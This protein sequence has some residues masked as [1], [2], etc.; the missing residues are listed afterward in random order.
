MS[1]VV[2]IVNENCQFAAVLE[3]TREQGII[4]GEGSIR[5]GNPQT[6]LRYIPKETPVK[7]GKKFLQVA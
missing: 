5:E 7:I 2:L 6:R 3:E 1:E 4:Q